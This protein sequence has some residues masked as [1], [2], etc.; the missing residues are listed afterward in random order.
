[1]PPKKSEESKLEKLK[2]EYKKI[3]E[4]YS[5]PSFE[6]LNEDFGIEKT[7]ETETDLLIR[8]IR[9]IVSEKPYN[10]LRFVETLINP[11]NAPMSILSIAKTIGLDEKNKLAEVYKKLVKQEVA[12]IST[13]ID[14]SEEREAE[15][16]KNTYA[17]WRGIKKE[18]SDVLKTMEKNWETKTEGNGR[19]YFG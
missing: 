6:E 15:F 8:E 3:Q 4:K 16:I 1:M 19:R 11:V 17:L 13:D 18:F 12:L 14:F 10:Y 9:K 2:K 7:Y 5:L